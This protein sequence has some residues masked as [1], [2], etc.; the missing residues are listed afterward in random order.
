MRR[1]LL[2]AACLLSTHCLFA[3]N[4]TP[5]NDLQCDPKGYVVTITNTTQK[6]ELPMM[7]ANFF[8]NGT[9]FEGRALFYSTQKSNVTLE[10]MDEQ[11]NLTEEKDPVGF[12]EERSSYTPTRIGIWIDQKHMMASKDIA[13]FS[14]KE[15]GNSL[16]ESTFSVKEGDDL[17]HI[18]DFLKV[19]SSQYDNIK[20]SNNCMFIG[21]I[22]FI[23]GHIENH[24]ASK[25]FNLK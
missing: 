13:N 15:I 21:L 12:L 14:L 25:V 3:D 24:E 23:N 8:S 11:Y 10:S 9:T 16:Y 18:I 5:N 17:T 22:D 1:T 2:A 20:I 4:H 6:D 7:G 19:P